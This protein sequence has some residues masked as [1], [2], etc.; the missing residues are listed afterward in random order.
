MAQCDGK[1]SF[2]HLSKWRYTVKKIWL[3]CLLAFIAAI[4]AL[5]RTYADS[6]V[7]PFV[8]P[9]TNAVI[10][11][12]MSAIDIDALNALRVKAEAANPNPD[13]AKQAKDDQEAQQQMATAKQWLDQFKTAGGKEVYIVM[14]LGG[15]FTGQPGAL[16]APMSAGGDPAAL[17]KV[18]NPQPPGGDP[19][20]G[21]MSGATAVIG[22]NVVFSTAPMLDRLKTATAAPSDLVDG[23][24]ATTGSIRIAISPTSVKTI[25]PMFGA[26]LG[27]GGRPGGGPPPAP[28]S[29]PEW[30]GVKWLVISG[31]LPPNESVALTIQCKDTDSANAIVAM[32]NKKMQDAKNDP[33]ARQNLGDDLDKLIDQFKPTVDGTK[34][35]VSADK[36]AFDNVIVP[37]VMKA[38]ARQQ[39]QRSGPPPGP[40]PAD[41]GGGM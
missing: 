23:L 10:Y 28:M 25:P 27:G 32:M 9:Q 14:E 12:D 3:P 40:P 30:S 39:Q 19:N 13:P 17:A 16:I 5:P 22:Q 38:A 15:L 20:P 34:V 2:I 26:M 18:L 4:T 1:E 11:V 21:P 6:P 24:N 37:I 7:A 33:K 41:N 8:S 35:T 29:E 31:S 36:A